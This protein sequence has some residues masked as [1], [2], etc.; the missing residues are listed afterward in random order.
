MS[1]VGLGGAVGFAD[2]SPESHS[3][4][5]GGV[6]DDRSIRWVLDR[7]L[8]QAGIPI[9]AFNTADQAMQLVILPPWAVS[10]LRLLDVGE[11]KPGVRVDPQETA[12]PTEV[13]V[14]PR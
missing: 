5:C 3:P 1:R 12:G 6:D 7:A 8:S 10:L 14:G 11:P 9:T 2:P 4:G 13:A